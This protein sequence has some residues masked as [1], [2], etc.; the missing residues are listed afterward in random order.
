MAQTPSGDEWLA[1]LQA[2][3]SQLL[4]EQATIAKRLAWVDEGIQM[5]T[6]AT[7]TP[8]PATGPKPNQPPP[9]RRGRP[10]GPRRHTQMGRSY[11]QIVLEILRDAD[12]PMPAPEIAHDI[13][14]QGVTKDY[15]RAKDNVDTVVKRLK[16]DADAIRVDDEGWKLTDKGLALATSQNGHP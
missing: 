4:G 5:H 11:R 16:N 14:R 1:Y 13:V 9:R 3:R 8:K 7:A 10:P 6:S 12:A 2:L 15:N